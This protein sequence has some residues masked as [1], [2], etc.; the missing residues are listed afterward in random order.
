LKPAPPRCTSV[1]WLS[2]YKPRE[3]ITKYAEPP[4]FYQDEQPQ[5]QRVEVPAARKLA[6]GWRGSGGIV[7]ELLVS[8]FGR[9]R[10]FEYRHLTSMISRF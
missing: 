10:S 1:A 9:K 5:H 3:G 7:A 4:Q 8:R 6:N 2:L